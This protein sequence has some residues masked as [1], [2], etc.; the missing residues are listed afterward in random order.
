M[1]GEDETRQRP[2]ELVV[3]TRVDDVPNGKSI[4]LVC[5]ATVIGDLSPISRDWGVALE[6]DTTFG[7][8]M[9]SL[10]SMTPR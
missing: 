1:K 9:F 7:L 6:E 2:I 3:L 5:P 8:A 10:L 4:S